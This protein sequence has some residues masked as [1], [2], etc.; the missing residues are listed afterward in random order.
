M[1]KFS[2]RLLRIGVLTVTIAL[3][4][5]AQAATFTQATLKG[6]Y[7]FLT[8]LWTASAS[9]SQFA[10]VGALTFDGAGNVTGSFTSITWDT[11]STG[12][13]GGTYTVNSNGTGSMHF[14]TGSKALF[15]IALNSIVGGV[16]EGMQL[17]QTNDK[18]N[19]IISGTAVL[20]S[21]TTQTYSLA[22]LKGSFTFQYN[23]RTVD[24]SQS[25]DGGIGI[26][27]FD[28]KGNVRSSQTI[29]YGG[30]IFK[31]SGPFLYTVNPDGT[32]TIEP[33]GV[34]G[35]HIAFALNSVTAGQAEGLQFLDTNTSD[36][37]GNMVIT[38]TLLKQ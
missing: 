37:A 24:A 9:T 8:N 2:R 27:T 36:G 34:T 3:A 15:S 5:S 22:S 23:P 1:H 30:T 16:A 10:M 7:G 13:L 19:E 17:L 33:S 29:V 31:G 18:K 38:G 25:E 6:S 11:V 35:P 26:F 21:T 32:G 20:Q 4:W 12:T 14:T 28:G